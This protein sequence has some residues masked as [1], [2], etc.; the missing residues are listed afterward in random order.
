MNFDAVGEMLRHIVPS[1][2]EFKPLIAPEV[3]WE[4]LGELLRFD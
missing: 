3:K 4:T 2:V 1:D